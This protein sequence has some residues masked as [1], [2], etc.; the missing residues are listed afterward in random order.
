[1]S[2]S[3][4]TNNVCEHFVPEDDA[5]YVMLD[6]PVPELERGH[7]STRETKPEP[8]DHPPQLEPLTEEHARKYD[9]IDEIPGIDHAMA[10]QM[11]RCGMLGEAV[12][13]IKEARGDSCEDGDEEI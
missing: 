4:K 5:D 8:E 2:D 12:R 7:C 13:I 9:W 1:M 3:L 11:E 10:K 6:V